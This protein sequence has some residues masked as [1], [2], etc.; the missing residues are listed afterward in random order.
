MKLLS[1]PKHT[2]RLGGVLV[3]IAGPISNI[4]I[5]IV[6]ALLLNFVPVGPGGT[7]LFQSLIITNLALAIFNLVPVPPLDGHHILFAI[8]PDQF[9][10]VKEFLRRYAF[11]ILIVFVI[12]GWKFISPAIFWAYNLLA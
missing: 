7:F 6:G 4:L 11:V 8:I 10:H 2:L 9:N 1:H 3:A 12:Y 5:A